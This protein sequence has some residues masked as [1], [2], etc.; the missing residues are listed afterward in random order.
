MLN[1]LCLT[2]SVLGGPR[3]QTASAE[4]EDSFQ[5]GELHEEHTHSSTTV[6]ELKQEQSPLAEEELQSAQTDDNDDDVSQSMDDSLTHTIPQATTSRQEF[7]VDCK[8]C[9]ERYAYLE[10]VGFSDGLMGL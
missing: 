5:E 3:V 10:S 2:P 1:K 7:P 6:T 4:E 9:I 8:H